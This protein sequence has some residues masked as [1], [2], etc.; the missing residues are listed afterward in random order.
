M[1]AEANEDSV[2]L[3]PEDGSSTHGDVL[4]GAGRIRSVCGIN[5][6]GMAIDYFNPSVRPLF[7]PSYKLRFSGKVLMRSTFDARLVEGRIIN[8][9]ANSM[10][11]VC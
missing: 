11:W 4:V 8:L 3:Y 9:S 2:I 10:H 1:D 6:I 5:L 7:C